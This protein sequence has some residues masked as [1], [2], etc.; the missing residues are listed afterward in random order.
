MVV[1]EFP[2]DQ[3]LYSAVLMRLY[4][5]T[6]TMTPQATTAKTGEEFSADNILY[7]VVYLMANIQDTASSST[8]GP[9]SAFSDGSETVEW[10]KESVVQLFNLSIQMLYILAQT[11]IPGEQALFFDIGPL[12]GLGWRTLANSIT[13]EFTG[14]GYKVKVPEKILSEFGSEVVIQS[15]ILY[16]DNPFPWNYPQNPVT[17][18]VISVLFQHDDGQEIAVNNLL[19]ESRVE[20]TMPR[21]TVGSVEVPD[22]V[23]GG[24]TTRLSPGHSQV[25]LI[26]LNT[27]IPDVS[28]NIEVN[29]MVVPQLNESVEQVAP[30]LHLV[31]YL[32]SG[33]TPQWYKYDQKMEI[34]ANCT[35]HT[36]GPHQCYTFFV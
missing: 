20:I 23:I 28:Y 11:R 31:V 3:S 24:N 9:G 1:G 12:K 33:Y 6:Q 18:Q 13:S 8:P 34:R 21:E 4:D 32:G 15:I 19:E 26:T 27:S 25:A 30:R 14:Y 10:A 5:M 36:G 16:A 29:G 17:S 22:D 7:S 35:S 2:R